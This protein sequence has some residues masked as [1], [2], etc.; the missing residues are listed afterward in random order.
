MRIR[1]NENGK[2]N[3][4]PGIWISWGNIDPIMAENKADMTNVLN[5]TGS[6]NGAL[7]CL[8]AWIKSLA[9]EDLEV[10]RLCSDSAATFHIFS[11]GRSK[12]HILL[13]LTWL[14]C[15]WTCRYTNRC[16]GLRLRRSVKYAV[17]ISRDSG[18]ADMSR[19]RVWWIRSVK[20]RFQ[21]DSSWLWI[22][23]REINKGSFVRERPPCVNIGEKKLLIT[24]NNY[25]IITINNYSI[26]NH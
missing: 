18:D 15:T 24:I 12:E 1:T 26:N 20:Y 17:M 14:Y 21:M 5:I 22:Y 9:G 23:L 7:V 19:W 11:S 6:P 13:R 2:C 3:I 10:V 16:N 4:L 25:C 8:I